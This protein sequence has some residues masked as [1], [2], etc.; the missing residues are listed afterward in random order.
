MTSLRKF[1]VA[2]AAAGLLGGTT[3]LAAPAQAQPGGHCSANPVAATGAFSQC[4]DPVW[5]QV[6]ITCWSWWAWGQ[7]YERWG[8]PA[9]GGYHSQSV[10]DVPFTL[11]HAQVV[12][13]P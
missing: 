13:H 6:K 8:N 4:G 11:I 3:L 10:C 9:H 5:H 12:V 1:T 7:T 2:V